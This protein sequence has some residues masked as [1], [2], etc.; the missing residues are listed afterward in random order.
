MKPDA[1]GVMVAKLK[2]ADPGGL[3]FKMAGDEKDP[4]LTFRK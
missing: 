2:L 4:G 1:G 3:K